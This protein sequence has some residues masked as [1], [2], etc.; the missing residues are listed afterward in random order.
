MTAFETIIATILAI[1]LLTAIIAGLCFARSF[2]F[3]IVDN[4]ILHFRLKE[5]REK[6]EAQKEEK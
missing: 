3:Y 4:I 5:F 2:V 1:I 6:M